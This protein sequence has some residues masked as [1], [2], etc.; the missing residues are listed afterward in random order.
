MDI[1]T[2]C[3][4]S[5]TPEEVQALLAQREQPED[6]FE[7]YAPIWE[8]VFGWL[9]SN[10][11]KWLFEE[12]KRPGDGHVV[13]IG[14]AFGRSTVCLGLGTKLSGSGKTFAVDPHTGDIVVITN[15][16]G[17]KG[18]YSSSDGFDKNIAR[19]GL[20]DVVVKIKKTSKEACDEWDPAQKI[21][22]LF[23]DGWHTYEAVLE[24]ILNWSDF[25]LPGGIFAIHDYR[26][27]IVKSA[28][29]DAMDK[30]DVYDFYNID[31]NMVSFRKA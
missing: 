14:S 12:S 23:V 20:Q 16:I 1:S 25:V 13:E 8:G 31:D 24:D 29:N 9:D 7:K 26:Q 17:N 21:R 2:P 18:E 6:S 22:L 5:F 27:D 15:M 30:L 4:F 3:E 19:F 11:G 10:Q 28:V